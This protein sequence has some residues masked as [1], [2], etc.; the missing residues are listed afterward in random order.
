M[1]VSIGLL[2]IYVLL[3]VQHRDFGILYCTCVY[4]SIVFTPSGLFFRL[5]F[6]VSLGILIEFCEV[7][8]LCSWDACPR[9]K[10][11]FNVCSCIMKGC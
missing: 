9:F 7:L 5:P 3:I 8:L 6:A 11:V 10:G 4:T 2:H 1:S